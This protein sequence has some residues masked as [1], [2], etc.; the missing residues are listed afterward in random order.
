MTT[1]NV[2]ISRKAALGGGQRIRFLLNW[3]DEPARYRDTEVPAK[4]AVILTE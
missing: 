4:S 2:L 1:T 3:T